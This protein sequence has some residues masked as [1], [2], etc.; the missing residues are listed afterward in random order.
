MPGSGANP[1]IDAADI[2]PATGLARMGL[3]II[4]IAALYLVLFLQLR[5]VALHRFF[6][7]TVRQH[8]LTLAIGGIRNDV[9]E[10]AQLG[11]PHDLLRTC[12]TELAG[13]A[14]LGFA[15]ALLVAAGAC[16][17]LSGIHMALPDRAIKLPRVTAG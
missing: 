15:A 5:R 13:R 16:A 17:S 9:Q 1:A 14:C 12:E 8:E 10:V 3:A 7:G 6:L 4:A 11:L 2:D